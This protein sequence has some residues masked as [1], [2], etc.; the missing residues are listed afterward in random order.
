MHAEDDAD[1]V[2]RGTRDN[3]IKIKGKYTHSAGPGIFKL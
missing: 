1:V 2:K 3:L